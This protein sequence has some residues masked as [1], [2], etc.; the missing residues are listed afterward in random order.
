MTELE[1]QVSEVTRITN[2]NCKLLDEHGKSLAKIEQKIDAWTPY[3]QKELQRSS[4]YQIVADDLK[5]K[6]VTYKFW[7]TLIAVILGL[8]ATTFVVLEKL[9]LIR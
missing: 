2:H 5:S 1:K 6:G 4:A 9:H 7:L 3:I 8:M